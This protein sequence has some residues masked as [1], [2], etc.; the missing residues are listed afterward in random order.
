MPKVLHIVTSLAVGGAQNHLK[1]LV[2]GLAA[3]GWQSDIVYFKDPA[4]AAELAPLAG[5]VRQI[6]L[7]KASLPIALWRLLQIIR[8]SD[9]AVVHTH[10][11]KAD[12]MGAVAATL[13]AVPVIS[14]KHNDERALLNPLVSVTHG[15]VSRLNSRIIVISRHVEG[16]VRTH[17]RAPTARLTH[18]PYGMTLTGEERTDTAETHDPERGP[19]FIS[20]GRLDPQKGYETLLCAVAFVLR[21]VPEFTLLIAGDTQHGGSG[22]HASLLKLSAELGISNNVT[23]LGVRRDVDSLLAQADGFVLAS[24][25][26]GFGLVFLEAM[27]AGKPVVATRVSAVPEV[28]ADGE[29]GLLVPADDPKALA[30]ALLALIHDPTNAVRMGQAGRARVLSEFSA[31]AMVERTIDVYN[32][33]RVQNG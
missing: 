22:Y 2:V 23:F 15:L 26:E 9:Y 6:P 10:L 20:V 25:W 28:V 13:A 27:A 3:H 14:T 24:R 31:A 17:G 21:E 32:A 30:L 33:C 1:A 5:C 18:V 11:L 7:G 8:S 16:F 19:Q 12:A 4:M 29:T